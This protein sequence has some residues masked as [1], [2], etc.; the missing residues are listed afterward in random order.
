MGSVKCSP[1]AE[2]H[3]RYHSRSNR[4]RLKI[5]FVPVSLHRGQGA[6]DVSRAIMH[7]PQAP[8]ATHGTGR[9]PRQRSNQRPY[10][11]VATVRISVSDARSAKSRR[12]LLHSD[13]V[14][15]KK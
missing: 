8:W 7:S 10:T 3:V 13:P 6:E 1:Q 11:S 5:R 14:T 2:Q 12:F 4:K 9:S 15:A